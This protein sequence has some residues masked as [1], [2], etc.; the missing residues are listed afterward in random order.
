MAARS[1]KGIREPRSFSQGTGSDPNEDPEEI[2][3]FYF[4]KCRPPH[5][6][7]WC[8]ISEGSHD[9]NPI[10]IHSPTAFEVPKESVPEWGD[11]N[12]AEAP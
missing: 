2:A 8:Q 6:G 3:M 11:N 1:I 5:D 10:G 12:E 9:R 4:V 7:S